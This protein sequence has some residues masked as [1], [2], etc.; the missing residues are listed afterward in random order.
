M[1]ERLRRQLRHW[2]ESTGDG[3]LEPDILNRLTEEHDAIVAYQETAWGKS[4][5]YEWHYTEYL[6]QC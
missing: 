3:L 5:S 1:Q 6:N 2:Q 4:R